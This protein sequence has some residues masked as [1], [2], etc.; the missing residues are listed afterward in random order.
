MPSSIGH[1]SIDQWE[2]RCGPPISFSPSPT[3]KGSGLTGLATTVVGNVA[4]PQTPTRQSRTRP[5]IMN[6]T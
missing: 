4:P 6:A 5:P 3:L 2:N 1:R